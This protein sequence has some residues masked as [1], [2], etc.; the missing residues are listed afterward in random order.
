MEKQSDLLAKIQEVF[1][2]RLEEKTGWGRNDLKMMYLECQ[3]EVLRKAITPPTFDI[4]DKFIL[5]SDEYNYGTDTYYRDDVVKYYSDDRY[6]MNDFEDGIPIETINR[7][8]VWK[9]L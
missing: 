3:N 7:E 2:K 5:T 9:K 4:F 8:P 6:R 1:F